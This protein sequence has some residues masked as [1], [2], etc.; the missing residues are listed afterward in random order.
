MASSLLLWC[1]KSLTGNLKYKKEV[2]LL[3]KQQHWLSSPHLPTVTVQST[4]NRS[5]ICFHFLITEY[6]MRYCKWKSH[7]CGTSRHF[8]FV[9]LFSIQTKM[10][11]I[12]LS[13][14][15]SHI[16]E[17]QLSLKELDIALRTCGEFTYLLHINNYKQDSAKG[18][19]IYITFQLYIHKVLCNI[20]QQQQQ[21]N[22]HACTLKRNAVLDS[23]RQHRKFRKMLPEII[24]RPV[25]G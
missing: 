12:L 11:F 4:G 9:L 14:T 18:I 13:M 25:R 16:D 20:W 24:I 10:G 3:L 22:L 8:W 7:Q 19:E 15:Y 2:L 5:Q 1:K 21:P 6:M 17:L 23:Q